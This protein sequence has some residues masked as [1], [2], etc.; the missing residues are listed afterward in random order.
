MPTVN[1]CQLAAIWEACFQPFPW[2]SLSLSSSKVIEFSSRI[3]TVSSDRRKVVESSKH[4]PSQ[5]E[6]F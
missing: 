2:L 5:I 1:C 6:P 3:E 4:V